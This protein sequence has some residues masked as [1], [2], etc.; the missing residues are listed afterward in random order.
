[1]KKI[2]ITTLFFLILSNI[3]FGQK[4]W[5]AGY[6]IKS[7]GD[8]IYGFIDNRDSKS[9][10]KNCYFR[11]EEKGETHVFNPLELSGYRFIDGKFFISKS[12]NGFEA[13]KPIF[14][15]FLINGKVNVY[16]FRDERDRYYLE[17]D[18]KMFELKNTEKIDTINY[19]VY[20][21]EK[22]EY[23][24]LLKS[25]LGDAHIQADIIKCELGTKSLIKIAKEYH[26]KVCTDEKCIVYEKAVKPVHVN[27]GIHAGLSM[28]IINFGQELISNY[29]LG[30]LLG[31]R[32]EFEN[33]ID[34]SENIS[35]VLDFTLQKFANYNLTVTE[36]NYSEI[37][38][39]NIN[40]VLDNKYKSDGIKSLGVDINTIALKIPLTLNYSFSKGTIRPYIGGG[41]LNIFILSQNKDFIYPPFYR[42]FNKSIPTYHF[43]LTGKVGAKKVLNKNQS[44]YLELNYDYSQNLN[45]NQFLQFK[46]NLFSITAGY[47]L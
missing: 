3:C 7:S 16:H 26:E 15:E 39:N 2:L 47:S 28:N 20:W 33:V 22:K 38:Y 23:I 43:G 40:Y 32:L 44:I 17:K 24:E 10:S 12:I 1:M 13:G 45:I 18:S 35:L 5:K 21:R 41:L 27:I 46:N 6:I 29:G 36:N 34:W 25:L 19:V 9:N 14:L 37:F 30:S 8:T 42:E 4:N 31:C 11:K